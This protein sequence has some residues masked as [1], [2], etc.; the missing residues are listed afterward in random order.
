MRD[1]AVHVTHRP[2]EIARVAAALARQDVNIKSIAGMAINTQG[3]IRVIADNI[4]AARTALTDA[5]IRFEE[6]ELVT[7]L[8]ENRAGELAEVASKLANVGVNI[9]AMYVIGLEGELVEVAMAVDDIKKAK[10]AL[11]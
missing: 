5:N 11:E 3:V 4:E 9:Q 2:G 1:F 8:L 7:A 10:R 6:S